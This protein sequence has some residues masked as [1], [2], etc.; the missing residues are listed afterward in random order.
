MIYAAKFFLALIALVSVSAVYKFPLKKVNNR[1]FVA[2]ILA[3]A[4]KGMKPSFR[5]TDDGSIVINDYENSQ[6]Y[7]EI[8]LGTPEQ[9]FN[10]IF[11]TGSSDL[12]VAGSGCD[13]SCGRHAKY[14][15]SASST[16][17]A[18]G[19]EF[20]IMYGSGPVSGYQS[21]DNLDMGGLIV[22]SQEF[23]EVTDA[24]GL[25]AAYKLGKFD[26]ILGMAFWSLLSVNDVT[27]PFDNL[28]AQ[29]LVDTAQFA[30]YLGDSRS[31]RGELVL[32]GTD[33]AH[34]T[35]DITW[36]NLLSPTYWEITL[37]GMSVDGTSYTSG[38]KAIVDSGTSILT[39]P[40]SVVA[41]IA[42]QVGAKEIIEGEYMVACNYDTLPDFVFTIDG[43]D[44]TL[45]AYDYL[46]PD[47]DLCL[48]GMIGLDMPP[49]TGPLWILG[50]IF[51]R[52]YY[53]V[54][55]TANERVGFA[56]AT[57]PN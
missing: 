42:A 49:P 23:A 46:L 20:K 31:D 34:Y 16:Y 45:T 56:L 10:V 32:G 35:G 17:Q 11:D 53:T 38:T 52:K 57:H 24:E 14:D 27:T 47:G 9:K 48:L 13:D 37:N 22:K 6:Y 19:T 25:G 28:V 15:S 29:G 33:P 26:G 7:G 3:R 50:D 12:W 36:V 41:S 39:A 1:E 8:A 4:A 2:G 43:N 21:V 30:F 54:F 40:S 55:D 51:M 5:M 44:Y 18:N